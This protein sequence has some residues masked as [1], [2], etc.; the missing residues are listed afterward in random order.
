MCS[1]KG[2]QDFEIWFARYKNVLYILLCFY[3]CTLLCC[4]F[5]IFAIAMYNVIV[6]IYCILVWLEL[7]A[8][9]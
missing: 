6:V 8:Q 1:G 5:D 7:L 9:V 2:C 3:C 4:D